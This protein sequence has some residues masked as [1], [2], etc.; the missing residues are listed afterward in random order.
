MCA[1]GDMIRVI[2]AIVFQAIEPATG[3]VYAIEQFQ[4]VLGTKKV[5]HR[6]AKQ[7]RVDQGIHF[8]QK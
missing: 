3:R 8:H 1:I 7:S 6:V 4:A 2:G 5:K